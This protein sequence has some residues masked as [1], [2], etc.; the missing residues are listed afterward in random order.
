MVGQMKTFF[1]VAAFAILLAPLSAHDNRKGHVITLQIPTEV[2]VVSGARIDIW[3]TVLVE[4]Q[5]FVQH[6]RW[7]W[8]TYLP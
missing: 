5:V 4:R 6:L 2:H 8:S 7:C 1:L 3:I